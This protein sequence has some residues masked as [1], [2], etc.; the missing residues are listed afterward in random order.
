MGNSRLH[1]ARGPSPCERAQQISRLGG[2]SPEKG[3]SPEPETS[4]SK[5]GT[6]RQPAWA[7]HRD[8]HDLVG[9]PSTRSDELR[10]RWSSQDVRFKATHDVDSPVQQAPNSR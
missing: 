10:R 3:L 2:S 7:R 6:G 5:A 8:L 1:A 4:Q 9:E